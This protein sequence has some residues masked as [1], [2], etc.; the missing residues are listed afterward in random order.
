MTELRG[1]LRRL[2][3]RRPLRDL[4]ERRA[5][6]VRLG[7]REASPPFSFLD[8]AR[9][10]IG[11]SLELCQAVAEEIGAEV[12]SPYL[13]TEYVKVTSETRIQALRAAMKSFYTTLQTVTA[14]TNARIRSLEQSLASRPTPN[15]ESASTQASSKAPA[16]PGEIEAADVRDSI[17]DDHVLLVVAVH[18]PF[19]RIEPA[20]DAR[21]LHQAIAHFANLA[22]RRP[23]ERQG[24]L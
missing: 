23:E 9:R 24:L 5:G 10:P 16:F 11:Y 17:V 14:G 12:D 13:R 1:L 18:R 4:W 20:L 8:Q 6:V 21:I 22:T 2:L 15:P 19:L 7:Y 3:H